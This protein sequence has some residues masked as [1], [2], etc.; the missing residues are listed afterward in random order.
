M[1]PDTLSAAEQ[2]FRR[3]IAPS[4]QKYFNSIA[5]IAENQKGK[6]KP[7]FAVNPA[8]RDELYQKLVADSVKIDR[9]IWD[10]GA[11]DIDRAIEDR[12]AKVSFGDTLVRR[13]TLKD[14]NQLRAAMDLL[15]KAGVQKDVFSAAGAAPAVT[16]AGVARRSGN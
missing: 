6:L 12:V 14:D 5:V 15:K 16:K 3:A 2:A 8:W 1:A 9:A 4:F 11:T 7:D 10:G 13:R